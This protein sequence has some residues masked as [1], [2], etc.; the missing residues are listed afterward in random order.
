MKKKLCRIIMFINGI[1]CFLIYIRLFYNV[2][3]FCDQNNSSPQIVYGGNQYLILSWINIGMLL[4]LCICLFI[5]I[6]KKE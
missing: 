3:V 1:I 2:F 5:K 4:V 6:I